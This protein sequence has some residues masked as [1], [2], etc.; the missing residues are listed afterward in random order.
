MSKSDDEE[1]DEIQ[2]DDVFSIK[3]LNVVGGLDNISLF[4]FWFSEYLVR[5]GLRNRKCYIYLM[6]ETSLIIH[7]MDKAVQ[8]FGMKRALVV[9]SEGL[10]ETSPLGRGLVLDVTPDNIEKFFFD[11]LNFV[12]PRCT[13]K[14]LRGESLEYNA[15]MLRRMLSGEKGSIDDAFLTGIDAVRLIGMIVKAASTAQMHKI[16]CRQFAQHLN[17]IGNLLEQLKITELKRAQNEIDQYLKIIPLITVVDNARVRAWAD[18]KQ[19]LDFFSHQDPYPGI[20][21]SSNISIAPP[22][23]TTLLGRPPKIRRKEVGET[24]NSGKLPRTG[25]EM[26]CSVCHVRGHN[27]R[28]CPHRAPSAEPTTPSV[29]IAT[30]SGRG[31]GRPKKT[32]TE[33]TNAAPQGNKDGSGKERGRPKKNP[34]EAPNVAP[35]GKSNGSGRGRGR[36]K[37]SNPKRREVHLG[38]VLKVDSQRVYLERHKPCE[39]HGVQ[40]LILLRKKPHV[41]ER[42]HT[43]AR[44]Y[45]L[46]SVITYLGLAPINLNPTVA[47][48]SG[49][50]IYGVGRIGKSSDQEIKDVYY[51][52][53]LKYSLLSVSQICDKGIEVKFSADG[54]T[55]SSL[56]YGK[57]ILKAKRIKNMYVVDFES[58]ADREL[59]CL[60]VQSKDADLWHGRLGYVSS[61]LLNKL[62]SRDLVRGMPKLKFPENK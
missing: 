51:V 2:P 37:I 47:R 3:G 46:N 50:Y 5:N 62:I 61:S 53:G 4:A 34:P 57:V 17:L 55:V 16:N 21:V 60:S 44:E 20:Q 12:I 32:P 22:E 42:R 26:T 29:A 27:K 18:G 23:I 7:K 30:D 59:T 52:N 15:E 9:H 25:L 6:N 49:G 24:K 48:S 10:D 56:K 11:S 39:L 13:L 31:R 40:R 58:V 19:S 43:L 14:S 28:G 35:Q 1:D 38:L 8:R 36:L 54:C 41:G 33:A 45:N